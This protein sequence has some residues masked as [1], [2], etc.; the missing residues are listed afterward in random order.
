MLFYAKCPKCH[1][2]DLR[3]WQ[4]KYNYPA[5]YKRAMLFLGAKRQRCEQCRYN[6][7]SFRPRWVP[8]K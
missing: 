2:L 1:E 5:W 4:E 7:V 8:G 3:D 6:F